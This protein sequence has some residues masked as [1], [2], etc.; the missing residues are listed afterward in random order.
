MESW[1]VKARRFWMDERGVS[2]VEYGLLLAL[3]GAAIAST[4]LAL[5]QGISGRMGTASTEITTGGSG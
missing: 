3:I 1:R 5:G 2:A 4:M